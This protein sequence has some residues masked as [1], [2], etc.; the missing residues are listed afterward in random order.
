[1]YF[2]I[3]VTVAIKSVSLLIAKNLLEM[4]VEPFV[5]GVDPGELF[6]Y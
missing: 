1:M 3:S 4:P 2:Y 5:A 6:D